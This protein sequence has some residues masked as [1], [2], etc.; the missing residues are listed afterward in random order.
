MRFFRLC[1]GLL[2]G[3]CIWPA[4]LPAAEPVAV[5]WIERVKVEGLV[6]AAKLDTGANTSSL[7]VSDI[8]WFV[9]DDGDWVAFD[10]SDEKG[11]KRHFEKKVVRLSRIKRLSS[12]AQK[13]PT[14]VLGVCLGRTYRLTEVNLVDRTGFNYRFLLGR[15][16]MAKH[17]VV[18]PARTY[19]VEP[20]CA[21]TGAP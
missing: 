17:F 11:A 16:F 6:I 8:R 5:G 19:T 21:G 3:A 14:V 1:R 7:H 20:E 10:A 18:D 4:S 13:R 12:T 9:R 15:R 2:V